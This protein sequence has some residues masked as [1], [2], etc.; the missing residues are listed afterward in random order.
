MKALRNG[1]FTFVSPLNDGSKLLK[2]NTTVSK[3]RNAIIRPSTK[4][5]LFLVW[6]GLILPNIASVPAA[7]VD[8]GKVNVVVIDAGHGGKDPGNLGTGRHSK[9]EKDVALATSLLLGKYIKENIPDVTVIYTRDDDTFLELHERAALANEVN[10]DLFISI[11]CN[12]GPRQ[13]YG[14]ETYVMGLTREEANLEVSRRENSVILLEDDYEQNYEGFDPNSPLS[15]MFSRLS[16]SA[17]LDQSIEYASLVQEQF[18]DRVRRRDRGVKQS[19]LYVL[20]YTAMPSV[21]VELGFLTNSSEEDFLLS[22]RGQELMASAIYRAFKEYK[23]RRDAISDGLTI[24]EAQEQATNAVDSIPD[25]AKSESD[26]T[27]DATAEQPIAEEIPSGPQLM[28]QIAVSSSLLECVPQNFSGL[29][30][31]SY[32]QEGRLYKYVLGGF[33]TKEEAEE[34]KSAAIEAG[35]EDAFLVAFM[36]G[37]KISVSRAERMLQ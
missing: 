36:D 29:E 32:Y 24:H 6:I 19:V 25:I 14:T 21:L 1:S 20:D 35:F 8:D 2:I 34:A 3:D 12:A 7:K 11:H 33:S 16:Q 37:D 18:K 10:A 31:V 5:W 28:V 9:K 4:R 15:T 26:S 27:L 23:L 17:Y 13:A 22:T 30:G